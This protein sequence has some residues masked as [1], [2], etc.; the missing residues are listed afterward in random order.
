MIDARSRNER[1]RVYEQ[2]FVSRWHW[3][4][5]RR[6]R[7]WKGEAQASNENR[8][9]AIKNEI[10]AE[11]KKKQI[12]AVPMQSSRDNYQPRN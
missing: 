2:Q 1:S 4:Q 3:G 8:S 9:V 6:K 5:G 10:A 7:E 12:S 11:K